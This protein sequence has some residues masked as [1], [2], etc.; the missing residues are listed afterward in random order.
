[1]PDRTVGPP[2]VVFIGSHDGT[3]AGDH[4]EP[5]RGFRTYLFNTRQ[6]ARLLQLRSDVLEARLG[7][8]RWATDLSQLGRESDVQGRVRHYVS[9]S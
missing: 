2:N 7:N 4:D 8:G 1:M 6:F 3:G 9:R 5:Y